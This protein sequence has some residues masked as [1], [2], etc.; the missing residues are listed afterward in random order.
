MECNAVDRRIEVAK[1]TNQW[2]VSF[3]LALACVTGSL[4]CA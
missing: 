3:P 2:D 4:R 1:Q